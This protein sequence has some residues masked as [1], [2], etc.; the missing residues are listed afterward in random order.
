MDA[1]NNVGFLVGLTGS[2]DIFAR[3]TAPNTVVAS[4]TEPVIPWGTWNVV[5][6]LIGPFGA[7]GALTHPVTM[8]ALA[9]MKKFDLTMSSD[10]GDAWA[11]FTLG[12]QTVNPLVLGPGKYGTINLQ[13]KPS[14]SAVGR[15]VIGF[16]YIDTF[17]SAVGTGDEV[18]RIPYAYTVTK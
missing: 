14:A 17:N 3:K 11:A 16:V 7:S 2:P 15:S 8:T 12:N 9:T 1:V 10:T 6:D 5:P 18:V 13:I 4:L